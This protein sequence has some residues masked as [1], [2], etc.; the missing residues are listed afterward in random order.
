MP[1]SFCFHFCLTLFFVVV[2]IGCQVVS[3]FTSVMELTSKFSE[4]NRSSRRCNKIMFQTFLFKS[5][6]FTTGVSVELMQKFT[7]VPGPLQWD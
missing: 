5:A 3:V 6:L 4:R 7:Y 2:V 1:S